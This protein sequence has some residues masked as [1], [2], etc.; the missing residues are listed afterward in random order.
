MKAQI[1]NPVIRLARWIPQEADD[2]HKMIGISFLDS[3]PTGHPLPMAFE[4]ESRSS[5]EKFVA[6]FNKK[7]PKLD[8][9][10][11]REEWNT[12]VKTSL[13]DNDNHDQFFCDK[14]LLP[15][16]FKYLYDNENKI[17]FQVY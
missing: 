7:F 16:L 15:P 1:Y 8:K 13:P 3:L 14:N 5:L 17:S 10:S 6:A 2:I 12:F 9:Q 4:K 11:V